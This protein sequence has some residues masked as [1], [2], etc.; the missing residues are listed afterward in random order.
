MP[1]PLNIIANAD[2]L[3]LNPSVNRAILFCFEQGYINSTSM[4]TNTAYFEET[5]NLIYENPSI[6]NIGIHINFA[7]GRPVTNFCNINFLDNNGNWKIDKFKKKMFLMDKQTKLAFLKEICAQIDKAVDNKILIKHIDSHYHLHTLPYF[8]NLFIEAAKQYKLK[9]RI[10]QTYR[11]GS[12]L[13]FTYRKIINRLISSN[14]NNY[15]D[16]FE[17]VNHFLNHRKTF[18]ANK[19]IEI[20]LHPDFMPSGQL[21]D[22]FDSASMSDWLTYLGKTG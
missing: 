19:T 7:E 8:Y 15:S 2:D 14:N 13:K 10:A 18:S 20:M 1:V 4:L 21:T 6:Q 9:L 12:I 17:N 22:H 5:V 3:G 11:E 16:Y